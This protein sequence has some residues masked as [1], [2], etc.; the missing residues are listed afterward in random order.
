VGPFPSLSV[1]FD[2]TEK[3]WFFDDHARISLTIPLYNFGE[4]EYFATRIETKTV[5]GDCTIHFS[6][7][8]EFKLNVPLP[9]D[10]SPVFFG[11]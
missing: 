9:V 4:E 10:A 8:R 5:G 1:R 7:T 11:G 6:Y 2:F 3:D